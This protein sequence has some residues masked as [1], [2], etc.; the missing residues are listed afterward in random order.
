M[1]RPVARLGWAIAPF[2]VALALALPLVGSDFAHHD[3]WTFLED[4]LGEGLGPALTASL[5]QGRPLFVLA[6]R[7]V[8]ELVGEVELVD[9][10]AAAAR[11]DEPSTILVDY[12]AAFERP[13]TARPSGR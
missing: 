3:D 12:A 11:A 13:A 6:S 9:A 2:L 10:A 5:Q 7:P 1:S 4:G 8:L